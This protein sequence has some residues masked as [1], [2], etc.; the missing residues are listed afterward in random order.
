MMPV[1][2][3]SRTDFTSR[4]AA[5]AAAFAR[6]AEGTSLYLLK[7]VEQTV[8]SLSS[9]SKVAAGFRDM[10]DIKASEIKELGRPKE[11]FY[12]DPNDEVITALARC[13]STIESEL[14]KLLLSKKA[15]IDEDHE[16]S[17]DQCSLLH[18]AFDEALET[19]AAMI[20]SV[21]DLRAV[22]IAHDLAAEPR[23]VA[24]H[25]SVDGFID[26]LRSA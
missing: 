15:A 12:L 11:G 26:S 7:A 9:L 21:K 8:D 13:T 22:V 6:T 5:H 1:R 24:E 10:S 19:V 16:L 17:A 14:P 3:M 25:N 2:Q 23:G 18:G 4:F 20:E